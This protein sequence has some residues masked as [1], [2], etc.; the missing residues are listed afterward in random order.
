MHIKI[1]GSENIKRAGPPLIAIRQRNAW[2]RGWNESTF[3]CPNWNDISGILPGVRSIRQILLISFQVVEDPI[4]LCAV[5]KV[6]FPYC[7]LIIFYK[8]PQNPL[9]G[10]GKVLHVFVSF[11]RSSQSSKLNGPSVWLHE[12]FRPLNCGVGLV[13]ERVLTLYPVLH[14]LLQNV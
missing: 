8:I 9:R 14:G 5:R 4:F 3:Y 2:V 10:Q 12:Q 6:I 13:Q 7:L 1:S 11:K